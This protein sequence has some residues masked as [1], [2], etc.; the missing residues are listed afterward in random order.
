MK[1]KRMIVLLCFVMA[2]LAVSFTLSMAKGEIS[3]IPQAVLGSGFTYQGNLTDGGAPANG[4]YDFEFMLYDA[5]VDGTFIGVTYVYDFSVDEGL[6]SVQLDFGAGVFDGNTRWLAIGVRPGEETGAYTPLEPRQSITPS[7]YALYAVEAGSMD[8]SGLSS[9]PT[10][11][12][13]GDDDT[14]TTYTSGTGLELVGTEFNVMTDT[15]QTRVN[16]YCAAGQSIRIIAADGSV[17]CENDDNTIYSPGYGLDLITGQFSVDTTEVQD[18]V[19]GDCPA[20][21]SIRVVNA[22]GS[23]TCESDADTVDG[24]HASELETHYHNV[25]VVAKSGGDF[26]SIQAAIYSITDASS[27]NRYLVYVAP[28]V[29][30]ERVSMTA[31]VDLAGAGQDLT[32][33]SAA[34]GTSQ[35]ADSATLTG[36]SNATLRNLTIDN[37]G[38][39]TIG[40]GIYNDSINPFTIE[41]V[42]VNATVSGNSAIAIFNTGSTVNIHD[43]YAYASGMYAYGVTNNGTYTSTV[44]MEDVEA[45]GDGTDTGIGVENSG[46]TIEMYHVMSTGIGDDDSGIGVLNDDVALNMRDCIIDGQ[47]TGGN[48]QSFYAA[49]TTTATLTDVTLRGSGSSSL[50]LFAYADDGPTSITLHQA[51]FESPF[52]TGIN[53][54]GVAAFTLT[55][56]GCVF[57]G[58]VQA[59]NNAIFNIATSQFLNSASKV[60][61]ATYNCAY[62]YS[63]TYAAFTCP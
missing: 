32:H 10:G 7:P 62:N 60:G 54:N 52:T 21:Q 9:V 16:W 50:G 47:S 20:G 17:T 22:D 28:G 46:V 51:T 2:F 24:L 35:N 1:H 30:N 40:I 11:L 45:W 37:T 18:R 48:G 34:G 49:D 59:V 36:A 58:L 14:D 13:D 42:S 29:Y 26:T 4:V 56:E 33:I 31:Y 27:S 53:G 41:N 3:A 6:F 15:I 38:G 61:V 12:D 19:D 8:W 39:N 43:T 63:N 57:K 55:A 44:T 5:E 25:V 23:V